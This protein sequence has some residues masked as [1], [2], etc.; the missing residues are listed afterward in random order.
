MRV[1]AHPV[2]YIARKLHPSSHAPGLTQQ[3]GVRALVPGLSVFGRER[4]A[5]PAREAVTLPKK[6]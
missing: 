6:R 4:D 2:V 3:H 5:E 1:I